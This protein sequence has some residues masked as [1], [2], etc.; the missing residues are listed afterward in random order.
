MKNKTYVIGEIGQ[1]HNGSLD[2]AKLLVDVVSRPIHDKLFNNTLPV[3]DAVKLTKRDLKQEL[4]SS[5]MISA[6]DN[7]NSFGKSY[8]EHRANLELSDEEHFE[9]YK[10]A[11]QKLAYLINKSFKKNI[12]YNSDLIQEENKISINSNLGS[13]FIFYIFSKLKLIKTIEIK[14]IFLDINN[15]MYSKNYSNQKNIKGIFLKIPRS[16][17]LDRLFRI[18]FG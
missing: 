16:Q 2:I 14:K 12:I 4:S 11:K 15:L 6:Y 9:V 7:N 1:N 3:M 18:I 5:Q 13:R 17:F 8:G 10:Y